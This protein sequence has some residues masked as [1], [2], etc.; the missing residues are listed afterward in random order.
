MKL[1]NKVVFLNGIRAPLIKDS[2]SGSTPKEG[3]DYKLQLLLSE[4]LVA[5]GVNDIF[6]VA[7]LTN[8][9]ISI[10]S[11]Y[12]LEEVYKISQKNLAVEL[13]QKLINNEVKTK[14]RTN[15]LRKKDLVKC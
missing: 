6:K 12:F 1:A 8:P 15:V 9:D 4:S 5:K 13:L 11:N 2:R 7:G 14:F 3:I 10:L